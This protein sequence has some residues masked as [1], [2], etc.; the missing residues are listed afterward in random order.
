L[1]A[2]LLADGTP[3]FAI[4]ACP[5]LVIK[6]DCSYIS[7]HFSLENFL[8]DWDEAFD[9]HPL[10]CVCFWRCECTDIRV[11]AVAGT[12]SSSDM[13]RCGTTHHSREA[14]IDGARAAAVVIGSL[15]ASHTLLAAPIIARLGELKLEPIT[16]TYGA[17]MSDTLS[18]IVFAICAST[19]QR[20]FSISSVAVRLLHPSARAV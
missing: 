15:L 3:C 5:A 16:V 18:L 8:R 12:H 19:F 13:A 6:R 1:A 9:Y 14:V 10:G 2:T 11:A 7:I 17:T 4:C 20:G